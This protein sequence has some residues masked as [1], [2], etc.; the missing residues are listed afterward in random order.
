MKKDTSVNQITEG[1]IWKQLLLF[2]F[3]ILLGTFF[4]QMY[5]TIDTLIVGRFVGTYALAAVGATGHLT[6]LFIGF[7]TGVG[8]GATVIISQRFGAKD[9]EGVRRA[10]HTGI[11]LSLVSGLIMTA[12]GVTAAPLMLTAMGTP[13]DIYEDARLYITVYF[14]GILGLVLYNI[15]SGILRAL[16][17]SKRPMI[18]LI[19][20]CVANTL[21]DILFIAVFQWGV[22]GAALATTFS[23]IFSAVLVIIRLM[24]M[25]GPSKLYLRRIR[26]HMDTLKNILRIGIPVGLQSTMGS[27]SNL[28]VQSAVNSFGSTL[29]AAWTVHGRIDAI[30][31][32]VSGA[33]SVAI[34]TFVGQNFGAQKYDRVRKSVRTC[35]G[36]SIGIMA[37]ISAMLLIFARPL[38][39][40]FTE[41]PTVIEQGM[42]V[43]GYIAPFYLLW[44]PI[45]VISGTMYGVGESVLPVTV[46][47]VG[48]CGVRVLWVLTM[49]RL[50]HTVPVLTL[51]Y[52]V[53]WCV[54]STIFTVIYLRG[55][56]LRRRI[57][58]MGYSPEIRPEKKRKNI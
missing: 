7:F 46:S 2:F 11:A 45:E 36:M 25:T 42:V 3:P 21:L 18:Y 17:D 15:G 22:A 30:V 16:G 10:V 28:I 26:F 53:T 52:P 34:T 41:E 47:G 1:V 50:W 31:W 57:E 44:M 39:G 38:F 51:T 12:V 24:R 33:F 58:A 9:D 13:A 6:Y 48:L 19:V 14:A 4:Q 23:Q 8:S 27:L 20:C 49:V 37:V 56:W 32:M 54:T 5:N 40:F 29:V 43:M 55:N 35:L